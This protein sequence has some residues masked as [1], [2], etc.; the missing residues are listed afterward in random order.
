MVSGDLK[1]GAFHAAEAF[2]LPSHQENFGF[3][4]V[5]ALACGLPVLISDKVNIW[6]EIEQDRAGLVESDD[7]DGTVRLLRGWTAMATEFH[8]PMRLSA[9][10]CF[11]SRFEVGLA[12]GNF[13]D[14]LQDLIQPGLE[15]AWPPAPGAVD[16]RP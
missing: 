4:V 10:R 7:L 15:T 3:S 2:V 12:A 13:I 14:V 16:A 1:W 8:Q 6:R 5:E 11:L 9:L